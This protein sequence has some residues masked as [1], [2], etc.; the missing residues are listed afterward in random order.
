MKLPESVVVCGHPYEVKVVDDPE[1]A[2][3]RAGDPDC[4]G[5][6][7]HMRSRIK[8]RANEQSESQTRDTLLHEV[9]HAIVAMTSSEKAY[10]KEDA[11]QAIAVLGTHLLDTMRRNPD[12]VTFLLA[13]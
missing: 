11:E 1:E 2:L 8:I 3:H 5:V 7:D 4:V 13:E 6:S 10:A 9:L 12:L